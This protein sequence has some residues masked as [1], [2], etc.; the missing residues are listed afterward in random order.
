MRSSGIKRG[1][2]LLV[3]AV[4]VGI[5]GVAINSRKAPVV[6]PETDY[7][8]SDYVLVLDVAGSV[9]GTIYIELYPGVAPKNVERVIE[10]AQE[11]AY[12]GI[13]FHRVIEGFMAQTGDVRY[14][15]AENYDPADVGDGGSAKFNLAPEFSDIPFGPGIVAMSRRSSSVDSANSQFFIML[16]DAP[17][18]N[19]QFTVIGRVTSGMVLVDQIK[20][21]GRGNNGILLGNPDYIKRAYVDIY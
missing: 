7:T 2:T 21:G 4:S 18:L 8:A 11:G 12:D 3:F 17:N 20:K 6:E 5:L 10:L 1:A 13:A 15:M 14:G 9:E 16:A 19:G